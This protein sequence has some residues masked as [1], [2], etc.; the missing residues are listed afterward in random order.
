MFC[1]VCIWPSFCTSVMAF[2]RARTF[3]RTFIALLTLAAVWG[4]QNSKVVQRTSGL[5]PPSSTAATV[6][7]CRETHQNLFTK[8]SDIA[9]LPDARDSTLQ[10]E[11]LH[12][13]SNQN[14]RLQRKNDASDA[15]REPLKA[16]RDRIRSHSGES[17]NASNIRFKLEGADG[18]N[19]PTSGL[20]H[21]PASNLSFSV[22][23][24]NCSGIEQGIYE[25]VR[26][27]FPLQNLHRSF[28]LPTRLPAYYSIDSENSQSHHTVAPAPLEQ[29]ACAL[30]QAPS[31]SSYHPSSPARLLDTQSCTG[32]PG[33]RTKLWT[34]MVA[35][36]QQSAAHINSENCVALSL[37]EAAGKQTPHNYTAAHPVGCRETL[38]QSASVRGSTPFSSIWSLQ[39]HCGSHSLHIHVHSGISTGSCTGLHSLEFHSPK[40]Q[41]HLGSIVHTT[42]VQTLRQINMIACSLHHVVMT[43]INHIQ[44]LAIHTYRA[45]DQVTRDDQQSLLSWQ[46][47]K[48]TCPNAS[49][50]QPAAK[51]HPSTIFPCLSEHQLNL[52]QLLLKVWNTAVTVHEA[53]CC[54]NS[55]VHAPPSRVQLRRLRQSSTTVSS[56]NAHHH[57]L[58]V[59]WFAKMTS[60]LTFVQIALALTTLSPLP[61]LDITRYIGFVL[62][63]HG[64]LIACI[65]CQSLIYPHKG[66]MSLHDY[67]IAYW[68]HMHD[69]A[70]F[71][72]MLQDNAHLY[73]DSMLPSTILATLCMDT[74]IIALCTTMETRFQC[75]TI[76]IYIGTLSSL[77][78]HI[79]QRPK[80]TTHA[81]ALV[82]APKP[83]YVQWCI[84]RRKRLCNQTSSLRFI[85]RYVKIAHSDDVSMPD[86]P[87]KVKMHNRH[88]AC[89]S[90]PGST[91]AK[92]NPSSSPPPSVAAKRPR[93]KA[94]CKQSLSRCYHA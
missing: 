15:F 27:E 23:P 93:P 26:T 18:L 70:S 50:T 3:C 46:L 11:I 31:L 80:Q 36:L 62:N 33:G 1:T 60:T 35:R 85:P 83:I 7:A 44:V 77:H 61:L 5:H 43:L 14:G 73:A 67:M 75:M 72:L 78:K 68:A 57:C 22:G 39:H 6:V 79:T 56:R 4:F 74:L 87:S 64:W 25:A 2:K 32:A 13:P 52:L 47:Q 94:Q 88:R 65:L 82:K 55:A 19:P 10:F 76:V 59:D 58:P 9:S 12:Q 49:W 91:N 34:P 20:T 29:R 54:S 90:R 71:F 89:A 30:P 8:P 45:V 63:S 48:A 42:L 41:V 92:T 69:C 21:L 81:Q 16:S 24:R 51:V 53:R 66:L 38:K 28:S 86:T 17:T 84:C 37:K 40:T